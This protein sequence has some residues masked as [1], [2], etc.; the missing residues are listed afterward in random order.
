MSLAINTSPSDPSTTSAHPQRRAVASG[1]R[2][3]PKPAR[4]S[5]PRRPTTP[6]ALDLSSNTRTWAAAEGLLS[7]P[8]PNSSLASNS[9]ATGSS[10]SFIREGTAGKLSG[11]L[12]TGREEEADFGVRHR[13]RTSTGRHSSLPGKV[14]TTPHRPPTS[15]NPPASAR[16]PAYLHQA[17]ADLK[18]PR[19]VGTSPASSPL[20]PS[21]T[22]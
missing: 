11:R 16:R 9:Q 3:Q 14:F 18:T 19:H 20:R 8:L 5:A 10:S 22:A 15:I 12:D 7:S 13:L 6:R 2:L 21:A 17:R 4:C 1:A